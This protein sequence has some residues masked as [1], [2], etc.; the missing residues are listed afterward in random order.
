MLLDDF[1]AHQQSQRPLIIGSGRT[2]LYNGNT[3]PKLW[4][5]TSG[6]S[7]VPEYP[8]PHPYVRDHDNQ[9]SNFNLNSRTFSRTALDAIDIMLSSAIF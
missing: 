7:T 2:D 4:L 8:E 9:V 1:H 6:S 3:V 5:K